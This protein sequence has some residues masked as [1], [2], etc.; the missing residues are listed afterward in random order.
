MI[1]SLVCKNL[2][3]DIELFV[4]NI[5]HSHHEYKET[6]MKIGMTRYELP[7]LPYSYDALEPYMDEITMRVHHTKH[8]QEYVDGLNHILSKINALSHKSY[9]TAILS[10]PEIVPDSARSDVNFYGG[11]FENHR[12]FWESMK[13]NGGGEPGGRLSD[14]IDVYF[15]SFKNFK[16]RFSENAMNTTGSGWVWLVYNQT[17]S[18]LECITTENQTS[19]WAI[20]RIPLLGL[21]IWEHA[22]YLKYLNE[23]DRYV[24]SWWNIVNWSEVEERFLRV[25]S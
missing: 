10:N 2:T 20:R 16:R 1:G 11:G 5:F 23:Q 13:P 21:E 4:I 8:H 6:R 17:F 18:R 22:Y 19:P 3:V 7:V 25:C 14:E 12:M 9:I 15:E 24:D